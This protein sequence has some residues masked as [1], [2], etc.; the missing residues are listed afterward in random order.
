MPGHGESPSSWMTT[1]SN[2]CY[3][4]PNEKGIREEIGVDHTEARTGATSLLRFLH[5]HG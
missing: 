2:Y 1:R 3:E 5:V 4:K